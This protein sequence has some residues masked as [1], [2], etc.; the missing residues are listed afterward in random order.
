MFFD[1][2][3]VCAEGFTPEVL[4]REHVRLAVVFQLPYR[5]RVSNGYLFRPTDDPTIDV[6][7]RNQHAIPEGT[8]G[9]DVLKLERT[10]GDREALWSRVMLV[11][12]DLK[13]RQSQVTALQGRQDDVVP[14]VLLQNLER[15]LHAFNGFVVAYW[16]AARE[17][18]GQALVKLREL[19][20][21]IKHLSWQVVFL[22]PEDYSLS[23][24]DV[25][26]LFEL[27][28]GGE[29]VT[30]E[31]LPGPLDDLPSEILARIPQCHRFHCTN[32]GHDLAF[33]RHPP[34]AVGGLALDAMVGHVPLPG[35]SKWTGSQDAPCTSLGCLSGRIHPCDLWLGLNGAR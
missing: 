14:Q 32:I 8:P 24:A 27:N 15:A 5:L 10:V 13:I 9:S 25:T 31:G 23:R 28:P 3:I 11:A 7:V 19:G 4:S 16:M 12:R 33:D 1:R 30:V 20:F 35:L 34:D 2:A 29:Y 18:E 21:L 6:H 26:H 17:S 22:C